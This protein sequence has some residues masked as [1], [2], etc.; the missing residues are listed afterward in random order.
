[1]AGVRW[2]KYNG[3]RDS[4]R[5]Q[6]RVVLVERL[7]AHAERRAMR[8]GLLHGGSAGPFEAES[9]GRAGAFGALTGGRAGPFGALSGG[10]A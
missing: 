1:M 4:Q 6:W 7:G 8:C 10:R 9:G 2:S 5:H 3:G